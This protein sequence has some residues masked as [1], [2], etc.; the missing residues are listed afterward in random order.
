MSEGDPIIIDKSVVGADGADG[1]GILS[2]TLTD[3][4][5]LVFN[6]TDGT[7]SGKIGPIRGA[8]GADGANGADGLTPILTL[9]ESGNL[10]VKYGVG[11]A[12]T[13]L[14]NIKGVKGD[15]GDSG[16]NGANGVDGK[17]A[18]ELYKAAHPE[19][20][21]TQE[22]WLAALKGEK[23]DTGRG[24]AKTEIID[25]HLWITYTDDLTNPTDV[26][27]VTNKDEGKTEITPFTYTELEDGTYSVAL[28]SVFKESIA[29]VVIPETFNGK[30][31]T[32]L[33]FAAFDG[34]TH[35]SKVVLPDSIKV[36]DGYAFRNCKK[37]KEINLPY[38]LTEINASAFYNCVS[39]QTITIPNTVTYIG[40]EAFK[41]CTLIQSITI[42]SSVTYIGTNPFKESG[43]TK[44]TFEDPIGWKTVYTYNGNTSVN[45][46][47]SQSDMS[48]ENKA[49]QL[50]CD[51]GYTTIISKAGNKITVYYHLIK[52]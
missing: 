19:Y 47:Y 24:I 39:L 37:L 23:G 30:A 46:R 18:Y 29:T 2:V 15:K 33:S 10:S 42:P 9:D 20:T 1:N 8:K 22:E 4:F 7:N 41:R 36:I 48:D 25:G 43:L 13:L 28:N 21:G 5:C 45:K 26:G 14:G 17:S 51:P 38:G 52:E 6:Y 50:L 32:E 12:V 27:L 35:L 3:D 16:T 11:G 49:A 40:A 31:V 44:A 34:V